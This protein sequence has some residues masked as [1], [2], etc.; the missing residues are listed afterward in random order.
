MSENNGPVGGLLQY[1]F[2]TEAERRRFADTVTGSIEGDI[3]TNLQFSGRLLSIISLDRSNFTHGFHKYPAKYIPEIPRWAIR[4]FTA[5]GESVL[6]PFCGSGTTN[7]EARLQGRNSYA[8]DVDP[9]AR[10]LT[11]VKTT[12]LDELELRRHRERLFNEIGRSSE[13]QVPEF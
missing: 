3:S 2:D 5:P 9:L 12:P 13:S 7:V 1:V 11:K 6:D 10:L 4:K 8:I